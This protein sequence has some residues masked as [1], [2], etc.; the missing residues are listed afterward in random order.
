MSFIKSLWR[1]DRMDSK[2]L[3]KIAYNALDDK[4]GI[5]ITVI[6][7]VKSAPQAYIYVNDPL[8]DLCDKFNIKGV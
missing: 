8:K 6:D 1:R 5:D 3:A 7:S 4:K 2:K